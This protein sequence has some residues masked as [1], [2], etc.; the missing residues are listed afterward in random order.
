MVARVAT[1]SHAESLLQHAMQTQARLAQK[2]IQQASGEIASSYAG[3]GTGGEALVSLE[4]AATRAGSYLSS[5]Q[6]TLDRVEMMYSAV[7]AM[8]DLLTRMRAEVAGTMTVDQISDLQSVAAGL[9]EDM[10]SQLNTQFEGR[11]LFAGSL[12]GSAPVVLDGYQATSLATADAG[13]YQGDDLLQSARIGATRVLDYGVTGDATAFETAL[14]VLSYVATADPLDLDELSEVAAL[15]VEA[16]DGIIALQSGL[17][18]KAA[19]LEATIEAE[20]TYIATLEEMISARKGVDAVVV[21]AEIATLET[22]LQ[23]SYAAIGKLSS[24]SLLDYLR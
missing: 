17:A 20:S 8:S 22:Q 1:F 21:A 11:Y 16:Q 7:G 18:T 4:V 15:L 14:R 12:T 24:M 6:T 3:L 5:A 23:A 19:T 10:A 9:L 2:Q 13:Y